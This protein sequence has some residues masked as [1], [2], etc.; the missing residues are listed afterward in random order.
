MLSLL[1]SQSK[2]I[3]GKLQSSQSISFYYNL[4]NDIKHAWCY[5]FLNFKIVYSNQQP[6][7][8]KIY[9]RYLSQ[10]RDQWWTLD[11]MNFRF[12]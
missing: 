1:I 9:T 2:N 4:V 5:N 8:V 12:P 3:N 7:L 11:A 10:Y 6:S